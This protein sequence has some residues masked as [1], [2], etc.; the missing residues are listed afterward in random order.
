MIS[1]QISMIFILDILFRH[2][3]ATHLTANGEDIKVVQEALRHA[4]SR[5]TLDNNM[6]SINIMGI[7][8][9]IIKILN[10]GDLSESLIGKYHDAA[11]T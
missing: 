11:V 1:I 8:I 5:I 10:R 3:Y 2:S 4:N 9:D 7:C 6:S